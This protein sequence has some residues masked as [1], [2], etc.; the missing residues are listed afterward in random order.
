MLLKQEQRRTGLAFFE[1]STRTLRALEFS[2]EERLGQLESI[3]A[4]INAREVI[5]PNEVDKTNGGAMTAD[6]KRIATDRVD[7]T[8][9]ERQ[10]RTANT[11]ERMT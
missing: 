4:Q 3:L 11:F 1:Y 6:A 2:D 7:A 9:C 5:V 10:K 8:R